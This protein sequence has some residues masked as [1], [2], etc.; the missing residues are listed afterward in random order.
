MIDKLEMSQFKSH[1]VYGSS[2]VKVAGNGTNNA[3]SVAGRSVSQVVVQDQG[4]NMNS[5][6]PSYI[7]QLPSY[8]A[9]YMHLVEMYNKKTCKRRVIALESSA[10]ADE[11]VNLLNLVNSFLNY[12]ALLAKDNQQNESAAALATQSNNMSFNG[13]EDN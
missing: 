2:S 7:R 11:F 10:I 12:E 9:P 8:R 4:S 5:T 1:R 13:K 6:S 3:M